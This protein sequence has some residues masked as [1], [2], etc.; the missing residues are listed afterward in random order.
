[1]IVDTNVYL[2]RWPFRHLEGDDPVVLVAKL[3]KWNVT[4]AW[5]GSFDGMLHKDIASVNLRLARDCRTHGQGIL[6]PFGSVNPKLPDWQE[7]VRRCQEEHKMPGIRLHPNYHGYTL[8]DP[9]FAELLKLAAGRRLIVQLALCMEDERT[10]SALMRVPPV[11]ITPLADVVKATQGLRL[12][13]LN[14]SSTTGVEPY[15]AT[16]GAGDVYADISMVEG[17]AGVA[18]LVH[19]IPMQRVLFGSFYPFFYFESAL[20]KVQESGLDEASKKVICAENARRLR[21]PT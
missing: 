2:S 10:Q 7:D 15:Q 1:M 20:F 14:C 13:L 16:L 5:A 21:G 18:R 3:R 8:D 12:E 9:V 19:E 11:D 4:E 6:V 17:V